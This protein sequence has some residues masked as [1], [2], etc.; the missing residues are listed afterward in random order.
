L[1]TRRLALFILALLGTILY[2]VLSVGAEKPSLDLKME[3]IPAFGG[4]FKYGEWL[5]VWLYLENS[6]SDLQ[7]EARVR[8]TH[9]YGGTTFAVPISLPTGSQKRVPVYVPPNNLSQALEVQLVDPKDRLLLSRR[10]EVKPLANVYYVVGLVAPERR[11]L[12]LIAGVSTAGTARSKVL[13]DVLLVELPEHPEGLGSFDCLIL[14]DVDTSSLTPQQS[15]ALET[16]VRQGGRLVIGGGAGARQTVSGLPA[17]LL[18]QVLL[19]ELEV[20]ELPGL[21]ELGGGEAVRVPGPFLVSVG[22]L[23]EGRTLAE[24]DNLPLVRERAIDSGRVDW[25]ALDL[26]GS[27]FDVWSGT[28]SFWGRLILTDAAYPQYIPPGVSPHQVCANQMNDV[29]SHLPS[30]ARPSIRG[31]PVLLETY[32]LL[33][34]PANY[35][36]LRWRKALRWAWA[37]V[38]AITLLFW[39]GV[40]GL[41]YAM[42]ST[43]RILNKVAIVVQQAD[44]QPQVDAYVGLFSPS[45]QVYEIEV[46]GNGLISPLDPRYQESFL[47]SEASTG[48]ETFIQFNPGRVRGLTANQWSMQTLMVE[49]TWP[50]LGAVTGDLWFEKGMLVGTVRNGTGQVLTDAVVVIGASFA[51]LGDVKSGAEVQVELSL[52]Q[53]D[54]QLL[55]APISYLLFEEQLNGAGPSGPPR[56]V[57]MKQQVL[58]AFLRS[59]GFGLRSSTASLP[60]GR[61][62]GLMLLAWLGEAP[63][64]VRVR[65]RSPAQQTTALLYAPLTY[66]LPQEG[67]IAVPAGFLPGRVA[68]VPSE[69]G[70]CA[71]PGGPAVYIERGDALFDFALSEDASGAQIDQLTVSI[72]SEGGWQQAPAVAL[73]DWSAGTWTELEGPTFGDNVIADATRL[74]SNGGLVRVRLSAENT[75]RVGCLYVGLGF[76]GS[77]GRV[78]GR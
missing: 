45:R 15:S 36:M 73:Y 70:V 50:D 65:G 38:P 69:G 5:P 53:R 21:T 17:A 56:D 62:Q 47:G 31:L 60:G 76:E 78:Y 67:K 34:G 12:S 11:V 51:R 48:E 63:P 74:A 61:A 32:I 24:Q 49:D 30:P 4:H 77:R 44:G 43:D 13:I 39:G 25:V 28:T 41:E 66:R 57:Q 14:N 26:A 72:R 35:L 29:L 58:D 1:S 37:T 54:G 22:D 42:N 71:A 59:D 46:M 52:S 9:S 19:H 40:F 3:A 27:P 55:G 10:V 7:A 23:G 18:P 6:G 64:E 2:T 20:D 8:V 75:A 16:W 68:E 33:V